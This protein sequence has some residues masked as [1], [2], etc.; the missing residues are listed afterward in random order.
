[1]REKPPYLQNPD[2]SAIAF[3]ATD[4]GRMDSRFTSACLT[5]G[6]GDS[7]SWLAGGSQYIY[8]IRRIDRGF[9]KDDGTAC[10]AWEFT[11]T[12]QSYNTDVAY[13]NT[14]ELEIVD[15]LGEPIA[16]KLVNDICSAAIDITWEVA[17][18]D[19]QVK[20][21]I[22]EGLDGQ[23]IIIPRYTRPSDNEI[24]QLVNESH[25][26]PE[27]TAR[28]RLSSNNAIRKALAESGVE[29]N[30][31][32]D[33]PDEGREVVSRSIF[34]EDALGNTRQV[35]FVEPANPEEVDDRDES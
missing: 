31:L 32:K 24:Q 7:F 17:E 14:P 34:V 15:I 25:Q 2:Q 27:Q 29:L 4:F 8:T 11:Q 13:I 12:D 16:P 9:A 21:V 19:K 30:A 22:A 33:E 3:D 35:D 10:S 26:E 20:F 23:E 18:R 28:M 5:H 6:D 1:M